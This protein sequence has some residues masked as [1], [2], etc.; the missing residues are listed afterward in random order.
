MSERK[1]IK[2]AN[3]IEESRIGGPQLRLLSVASFLQNKIDVTAIIPNSGSKKFQNKCKELNVKFLLSPMTNINRDWKV[4]LKYLIFFPYETIKLFKILKKYR[5]DI[6]HLSGGSWQYKGLLAAKLAG[7]KVIWELN[8]TYV[9]KIIMFIFNFLNRLADYFLYSSYKT[10]KYYEKIIFQ[11]KNN[12]LIQSPVDTNLFNPRLKY[13]QEKIF[14]KFNKKIIVGTVCN[15]NPVKDLI[16]LLKATKQLSKYG[17]KILFVIIGPVYDTQKKYHKIL[18][19]FIKSSKIKN[20]KF[21]LSRKDVRP[22]LKKIDIYVC[23]SKNESSPL[24]VWE[25]MSMEKPI[26]ST[27]VGDINKFI[28]NGKNGFIVN[29]G[30]FIKMAEKISILIKKPHLRLKFGKYSRKIAIK[31]L[32]LKICSQQHI[33]MYKRVLGII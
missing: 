32:D 2:I 25:A 23:S 13:S 24:S 14:N 6:V 18:I 31:K 28:I 1:I 16:T 33:K 19:N 12:F 8:D 17:N 3:I 5:F 10:K 7:V 21:L 20:C 26:V 27:N 22:L 30:D 15:I 9:P 4:I 29:S 11:K